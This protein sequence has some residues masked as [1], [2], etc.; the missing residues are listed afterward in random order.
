MPGLDRERCARNIS[1]IMNTAACDADD[2]NVWSE[3][4]HKILTW[5]SSSDGTTCFTIGPVHV[6]NGAACIAIDES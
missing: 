5:T 3:V 6:L 4:L 2:L 1:R